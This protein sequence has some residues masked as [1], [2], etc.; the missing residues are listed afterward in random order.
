MTEE[1]CYQE[2]S[3]GFAEVWRR[4]SE[5]EGV[6]LP[7]DVGL[8]QVVT[9]FYCSR[10]GEGWLELPPA[11]VRQR[12]VADAEEFEGWLS[13]EEREDELLEELEQ[14]KKDLPAS[15]GG[16]EDVIEMLGDLAHKIDDHARDIAEIRTGLADNEKLLSAI[17][18]E[19]G[20]LR[21]ENAELNK[22]NERLLK[23]W[24]EYRDMLDNCN[25]GREKLGEDLWTVVNYLNRLR[26]LLPLT[27]EACERAL[28]TLWML[29]E[30]D[31]GNVVEGDNGAIIRLEYAIE[32]LRGLGEVPKP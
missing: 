25:E 24:V 32:G 30:D 16:D 19:R 22:S 14:L 7:S 8:R 12:G 15:S 6:P 31:D 18:A 28:S 11:W 2:F 27:L 9:I 26:P 3:S 17:K 10:Y 5:A 29:V 21:A 4:R 1:E 20:N 13:L 23:A